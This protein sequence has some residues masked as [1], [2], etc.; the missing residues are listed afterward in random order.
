MDVKTV[1]WQ[2]GRKGWMGR[3]QRE[4]L[5][6]PSQPPAEQQPAA[7]RETVIVVPVFPCFSPAAIAALLHVYRSNV[8]YWMESGKLDSFED[9][10][11]VRYVMREEL[12][13]FLREFLGRNVRE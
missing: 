12:I 6:P 1:T 9:N 10:I 4:T 11:G 8:Q 13:R 2:A 7:V 3:P 5:L